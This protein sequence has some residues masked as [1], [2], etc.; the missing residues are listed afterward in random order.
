M[1]ILAPTPP[2]LVIAGILQGFFF[3]GAPIVAAMERELVPPEQMG[4]WIGITRFFKMILGACM[5][6]AAGIIWDKLGPQYIFIAFVSI[7]VL[8]RMPLLISLPET[9]HSHFK[10]TEDNFS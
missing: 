9:L 7:D 3:I 6:L 5:A 4:R 1:L 2:Y 10:P 8:I